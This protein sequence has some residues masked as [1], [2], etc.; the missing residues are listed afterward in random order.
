MLRFAGVRFDDTLL[1]AHLEDV[2]REVRFTRAER[3]VLEA[4][5]HNPGRLLTRDQ[6]LDAIGGEGSDMSDRRV[7]F[8]INRLRGKLMDPARQPRLIE[9]RYGEGYVWIAERARHV[10]P[11]GTLLLIGPIHGADPGAAGTMAAA[12]VAALRLEFQALA[13]PDQIV[14]LAPGWR[15]ATEPVAGLQ[16]SLE[17]GFDA[18]DGALHLA[19]LL[20][21]G[22]ARTIV[23]AERRRL[24]AGDNVADEAKRLAGL[25]HGV[26]WRRLTRGAS[27][28]AI[29]PTEAPLHVRL[30]EAGRRFAIADQSWIVMGAQLSEL[31]ADRSADPELALMWGMHLY[32][33]LLFDGGATGITPQQRD[34][35]CDD[36][37]ERVFTALPEIDGRPLLML[38]AAKLLYFVH[39]GHDELADSLAEQAFAQG[40]AFAAA[41][42][43]LGQIALF[44]GD[45]ERAA[46]LFT[47]AI[48]MSERGSDFHLYLLT[49]LLT[50]HLAA[51]DRTATLG[52][53]GELC[54]LN[55]RSQFDVGLFLAEPRDDGMD[56]MLRA[57]FD[58]FDLERVRN[59][60]AYL[61]FIM[62]RQLRIEAQRE[63]IMAGV[64]HHARRR[65][66]DAAIP[67]D[68]RASVP[69]LL[70]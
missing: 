45:T 69:R 12:L 34:A 40:T 51:G 27:D 56:P 66:G 10:P 39:R 49:F 52:T 11:A 32:A 21:E 37:E 6:L 70:A 8:V 44:R 46:D 3:A 16:F 62:G 42:S 53:F 15:P 47:R 7:D 41:F 28:Q 43:M 60:V 9:T 17:L 24:A 59:A 1:S 50:A 29:A 38:A 30:H 58:M 19:A 55:P 4:F 25:L 64:V 33:R 35:F 54:A 65:F 67:D 14:A 61:Y 31:G 5:L 26:M 23:A 48:A 13:A 20:R 36:V 18:R 2:D 22:T 68:V 57:A 63:R